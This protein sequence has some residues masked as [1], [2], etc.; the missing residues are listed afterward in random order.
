MRARFESGW[1]REKALLF[2]EGIYVDEMLCRTNR[3]SLLL[4]GCIAVCSREKSK[5]KEV[6]MLMKPSQRNRNLGFENEI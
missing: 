6:G 3:T 2:N 5:L 4:Q 1:Y